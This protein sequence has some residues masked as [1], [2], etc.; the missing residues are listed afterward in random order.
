MNTVA[1]RLVEPEFAAAAQTTTT[2]PVPDAAEVSVSQ[3]AELLAVHAHDAPVLR[4]ALPVPAA[5]EIEADVG[6]RLY[7]HTTFPAAW[8]TVR[9]CAPTVIM[10]MRA[11]PAFGATE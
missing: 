2:D 5:A 9:V 11:A 1:V 3:E 6:E 8:L 7:V 10:P 4:L